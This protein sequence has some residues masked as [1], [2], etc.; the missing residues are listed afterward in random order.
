M[1]VMRKA[2]RRKLFGVS[3]QE[4]RLIRLF[5]HRERIW[6]NLGHTLSAG[7]TLVQIL[8]RSILLAKLI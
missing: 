7:N 3:T 4:Q 6:Q 1:S 8:S 2:F 5:H